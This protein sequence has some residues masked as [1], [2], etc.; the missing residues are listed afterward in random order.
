MTE[1][2]IGSPAEARSVAELV[3]DATEQMSRLIRDEIRLAE[4]E[5]RS[6]SQR[7]GRGVGLAGAGAV[8]AFYGGAAVIAS[9]IIALVGP[10]PDWGAPL[11]VGAVLLFAGAVLA[12][13]GRKTVRQAGPPVP[14]EAIAGVE[15]D[16]RTI[17]DGRHR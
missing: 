2:R 9:A 16:I 15:E 10:L 1:T 7:M 5:V 8:S 3:S 17:K 14:R 11:I 4:L 13:I 12:L 6:K